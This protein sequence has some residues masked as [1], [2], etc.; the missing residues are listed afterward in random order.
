MSNIFDQNLSNLGQNYFNG[1]ALTVGTSPYANVMVDGVNDEVKVQAAIDTAASKEIKVVKII[2]DLNLSAALSEVVGGSIQRRIAVQL[3]DYVTVIIAAGVKINFNSGGNSGGTTFTSA[4]GNWGNLTGANV[5]CEGD[6]AFDGL[7]SVAGSTNDRHSA[8]WLDAR[9]QSC[10]VLKDCNV[11]VSGKRTAGPLVR[12]Y[13]SNSLGTSLSENIN[14]RIINSKNCYNALLVERN[15][16][17]INSEVVNA[18][19]SFSDGVVYRD[20]VENSTLYV[21]RS[22]NNVGRNV[23]IYIDPSIATKFNDLD[24]T[25]HVEAS[26]DHGIY[27]AGL[28]GNLRGSSWGNQKAGVYFDVVLNGG[29]YYYPK[30]IT[31]VGFIAK[32]NNQAGSTW[33]GIGGVAKNLELVGFDSSDNQISPTQYRGVDFSDSKNDYIIL[34]SGKSE[35]N[36]D[37][38]QIVVKGVNSYVGQQVVGFN[39]VY[40]IADGAS[41]TIV[42]PESVYLLGNGSTLRFPKYSLFSVSTLP[43]YA[44]GCTSGTGSVR[45]S[46]EDDLTYKAI[47]T[48]TGGGPYNITSGQN[49]TFRRYTDKWRTSNNNAG[50]AGVIANNTLSTGTTLDSNAGENFTYHGVSRQAII[51]G[52]FRRLGVSV[53]TPVDGQYIATNWSAY[54]VNTGILPTIR[55]FSTVAL[56]SGLVSKT[57]NSLRFTVNSAGSGFGASNYFGIRNDI[58]NGTRALAGSGRQISISFYASSNISGKKLGVYVIQNYGSGGAPTADEIIQGQ[59]FVLSSTLTKYTL[60]LNLN[61]L[62]GKTFGT[63]NNDVLRLVFVY[64]WGSTAATNVGLASPE[65]FVGSG[66]VEIAQ[67]QVNSGASVLPFQFGDATLPP[68]LRGQYYAAAYMATSPTLPNGVWIDIP[69][70]AETVDLNNNFSSGVYTAPFDGLLE[71]TGAVGIFSGSSVRRRGQLLVNGSAKH[72]FLD[73]PSI[74]GDT[75]TPFALTLFVSGG[76]Q[77]KLQAQVSGADGNIRLGELLTYATFKMVTY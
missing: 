39:P 16:Q 38:S 76:Q 1:P 27:I 14:I 42:G 34:T 35:G 6:M 47:D 30:K 59:S 20:G 60:T 15:G 13:N 2:S 37:S 73:L 71:V 43:E 62:T 53:A 55:T 45:T 61:T 74:S 3:K 58:F 28:N 46:Q 54:I 65:T 33:S 11:I 44:V 69:F 22:A 31:S 63:N 57:N 8:V 24:V 41:Y 23:S 68:I 5:I 17:A 64:M 7:S 72:E 19:N 49:F 18:S 9:S 70:D 26:S 32:N 75:I 77:V 10:T 40:I 29:T 36:T 67:V 4:F 50:A 21:L 56:T 12:L 48:V 51:N 52:N 25:A 66:D